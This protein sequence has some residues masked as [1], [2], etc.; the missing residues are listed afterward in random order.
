MTPADLRRILL[1]RWPR[2]RV[3][4]VDRRYAAL[5]LDA[6]PGRWPLLDESMGWRAPRSIAAAYTIAREVLRL[7]E[8]APESGDCDDYAQLWH[9]SARAWHRIHRDRSS[10]PACGTIYGYLARSGLG[11]AMCWALMEDGTIRVIEPQPGPDGLPTIYDPR[12]P[13]PL[14][15][16]AWEVRG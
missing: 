15:A 7:R 4:L 13:S 11:H 5:P 2:A 9:A 12:Q 1:G 8:Y 3:V 14:R 16:D 6:L 10:A